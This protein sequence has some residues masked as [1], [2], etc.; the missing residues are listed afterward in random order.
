MID[1]NRIRESLRRVASN[2]RPGAGSWDR[3][4]VKGHT[5]GLI[6]ASTRVGIIGFALLLSTASTFGVWAALHRSTKHK[7]ESAGQSTASSTISLAVGRQ[8]SVGNATQALAVGDGYVWV[9][10]TSST[11]CSGSIEQIDPSTGQITRVAE[12]FEIVRGLSFDSG[13]LWAAVHPCS[14]PGDEVLGMDA[15]TFHVASSTPV[16]LGVQSISATSSG[17]W[18]SIDR[19]GLSG[20]MAELSP[21]SGKIVA[22]ITLNGRLRDVVATTDGAWVLDTSNTAAKL[23]QLDARMNQVATMS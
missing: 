6:Q 21:Q 8:I 16:D 14:S 2:I 12:G 4:S 19:T 15:G 18:L 5:T 22:Q 9:A 10:A 20:E 7:A 3:L 1:E 23:V 17:V 11:T 13:V